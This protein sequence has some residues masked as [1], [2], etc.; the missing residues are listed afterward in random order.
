MSVGLTSPSSRLCGPRWPENNWLAAFERR[1]NDTAIDGVSWAVTAPA[2]GAWCQ[3]SSVWNNRT[4][5]CVLPMGL[6][7]YK[8][9]VSPP[10]LSALQSSDDTK[11]V[12]LHGKSPS[13]I[14]N[15]GNFRRRTAYGES[16]EIRE[17]CKNVW[18]GSMETISVYC[19]CI[20]SFF[21]FF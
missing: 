9:T 4:W 8:Y 10:A 21:F 16:L 6:P 13:Q 19:F 18:D 11:T 1:I 3:C 12:Q 7:P 15:S 17:I 5:H 20:L 2:T 14:W